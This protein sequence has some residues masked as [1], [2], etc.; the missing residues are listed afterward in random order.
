MVCMFPVYMTCVR[1]LLKGFFSQ[2]CN[3]LFWPKVPF[4]KA[5]VLISFQ[6]CHVDVDVACNLIFIL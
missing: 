1:V 2:D 6:F 3:F 4:A 5:R